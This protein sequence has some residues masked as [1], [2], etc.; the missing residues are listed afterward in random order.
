MTRHASTAEEIRLRDGSRAT[1]RPIQP[2][3]KA[4]IVAAFAQLSPDSRY[5]RFFTTLDTLDER[6]L[7]FLTEIDHRDHEALIAIEPETGAGIGVARFVRVDANVAE[8]AIVV[9][10]R[11]QRRGL[12]LALLERLADH[13]RAEG[14]A[15]FSGVV[16]V[17]NHDALRLVERLGHGTLECSSPEVRFDVAL[18][19]RSGAGHA[20]GELLR[21]VAAGLLAPARLLMPRGAAGDE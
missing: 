16:L 13:A 4:L 12:G 14:I 11:W 1:I 9:V 8:P 20:L 21:A 3:D 17:E 10:D 7:A 2:D 5:R 18:P 6:R 19:E 15:R